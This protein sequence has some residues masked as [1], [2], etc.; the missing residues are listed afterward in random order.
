MVRVLN[1]L[2]IKQDLIGVIK[3]LDARGEMAIPGVVLQHDT[4]LLNLGGHQQIVP[5]LSLTNLSV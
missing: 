3:V 4:Y 2:V 5:P 1:N